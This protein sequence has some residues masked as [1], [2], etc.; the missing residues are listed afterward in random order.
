MTLPA[1]PPCIMVTDSTA[2]SIGRLLRLMMVCQACTT[3]QAT[4][5]GS[6]ARCGSAA[7]PPAPRIT[8]WKVLADAITGPALQARLPCG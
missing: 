5:M 3:W 4:G 2:V 7:W 1:S 6:A 8:S